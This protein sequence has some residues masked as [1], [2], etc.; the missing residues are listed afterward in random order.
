MGL[1]IISLIRVTYRYIHSIGKYYKPQSFPSWTQSHFGKLV[2]KR[3]ETDP[4]LRRLRQR[5]NG[6]SGGSSGSESPSD[7]R[8]R[9]IPDHP[10]PPPPP[11]PSAPTSSAL[12]SRVVISRNIDVV[13]SEIFE[14]ITRDFILSWLAP[15]SRDPQHLVD[16]ARRLYWDVL[17]NVSERLD[18]IDLVHFMSTDLINLIDQHFIDIR[19]ATQGDDISGK[20]TPFKPHSYLE[21]KERELKFLRRVADCVLWILLP[22]DERND[23]VLRG[24]L[25]EVLAFDVLYPSI[26][27]ICDPDYIN[28]SL[29]NWIEY[30]ES[31]ATA[32]KRTYAYAKN[33]EEFIQMIN[34]SDD[35]EQLKQIR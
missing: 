17:S 8:R 16:I 27:S 3:A 26:N 2:L 13:F 19:L 12:P 31:V 33:Y 15:L 32:Q 5:S 18:E 4:R 6:G 7:L 23:E 25:R 34:D 24:L 10:P 29:L 30:R 21:N 20:R 35:V 14:L 22:E 11:P 1:E 28:Q 9:F